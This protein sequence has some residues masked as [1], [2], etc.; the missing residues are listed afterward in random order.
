MSALLKPFV[1]WSL[2][3]AVVS[4][5]IRKGLHAFEDTVDPHACA[6]LLREIRAAR[7]FDESLF[8]TEAEFDTDPQCTGAN[9]RPRRNL[10]ERLQPKLAF[11]ESA[12]HLVEALW[13]LL[14]PDY[15]ILDKKVVCALPT[16]SIPAWVRR[17]IYRRPGNDLGAYIRP[18]YRDAT[19]SCGVDFRQDLG[20]YEDRAADFV[21]VCVYLH[22]VGETDAPLQALE[23]SHR[24]GASVFPHDLK[25]T[26]PD[27]WRYRNGGY[28]DMYVTDNVLTG[29]AGF[30]ALWHACTLHGAQPDSAERE[31]IS[32][33]YLVARGTAKACGLDTVNA[34]LAG[35]LSLTDTPK[36]ADD[37]S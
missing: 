4:D 2:P 10:L 3:E 20:D 7:R 26:G 16:G 37:D 22:S 27:A 36:D 17:R 35:P 21:T 12:P 11:V 1:P 30:A 28:G 5:L 15:A 6:A 9:P 31:R 19:Y 23:G 13:T 33:R 34:T 25:R 14:G 29:E 32:L 8:L 18:E 24:M